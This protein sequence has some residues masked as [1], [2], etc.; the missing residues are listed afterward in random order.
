MLDSDY[1]LIHKT[2]KENAMVDALSQKYDEEGSL[3]TLSFLIT[4][5]LQVVCQDWSMDAKTMQ[6]IH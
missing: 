1:K 3:F 6:M 5:F 2:G 4:G